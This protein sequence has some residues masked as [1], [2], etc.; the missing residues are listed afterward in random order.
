MSQWKFFV[1]DSQ[2]P[3]LLLPALT[4]L[5]ISSLTDS[6][7]GQY[8]LTPP[9]LIFFEWH[10]YLVSLIGP[11]SSL[12]TTCDV[13]PHISPVIKMCWFFYCISPKWFMLSY[14]HGP[15]PSPGH[16]SLSSVWKIGFLG[17]RNSM[18]PAHCFQPSI[19]PHQLLITF[20]NLGS[21]CI[22]HIFSNPPTSPYMTP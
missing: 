2:T 13:E 8:F 11:K 21:D 22:T 7:T 5:W 12:N 15:D 18:T 1:A 10:H 6:A 19:W 14:F 9:S 4:V 3:N 17:G 16:H 20:L